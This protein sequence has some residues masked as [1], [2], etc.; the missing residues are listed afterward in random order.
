[1]P[2]SFLLSYNCVL[3]LTEEKLFNLNFGLDAQFASFHKLAKSLPR[4]KGC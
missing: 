1:M 4:K 2:I 3:P